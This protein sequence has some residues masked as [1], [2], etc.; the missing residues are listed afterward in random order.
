MF[1]VVVILSGSFLISAFYGIK[2]TIFC[3]HTVSLIQG[4]IMILQLKMLSFSCSMNRCCDKIV[5]GPKSVEVNSAKIPSIGKKA[6][7]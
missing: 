3:E 1:H 4:F 6:E 7:E 5:K 2:I